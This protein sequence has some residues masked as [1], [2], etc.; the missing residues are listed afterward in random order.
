MADYY[1][2]LKKTIGS[3]PE[4][5]GAARRSVYSRARNAIVNQLKAYEPPL[6]PSEITAEQLRLEEAIRKVEAE[7]ARESLGLTAK[8]KAPQTA[9]PALSTESPKTPPPSPAVEV[10]P[11]VP[12][13]SEINADTSS[14]LKRVVEEAENLGEATHKAV[15]STKEAMTN[16]EPS[17]GTSSTSSRQE[18]VLGGYDS[19]KEPEESRSAPDSQDAADTDIFAPT[20]PEGN[21]SPQPER[22]S[23][24]R[25]R[26]S[27]ALNAR[28]GKFPVLPV[29]LIGVLV[30]IAVGIAVVVFSQKDMLSDMMAGGDT[31]SDQT[32]DVEA[33]TGTSAP[34]TGDDNADVADNQDDPNKNEDRLL[35]DNGAPAAAPDARSVTTTLI[36]PNATSSSGNAVPASPQ[37]DETA[38]PAGTLDTPVEDLPA[39]TAVPGEDTAPVIAGDGTRFQK[40]ILYEEGETANGAGSAS[41][42]QVV[43]S[44]EEET[45]L[46][47]AKQS[48]LSAVVNVPERN[49]SVDIR[50]KPN[51]DPS[52]PASHL[53]E[54]KYDFPEDFPAG[55][56]VN[57]PG[58]VMKPTEEARGDALIGASVKVSPGYF[59]I[60]LSSIPSEMER[61]MGLLRE[62]GWVDIPMLYDNGKRGI[63]TLEKGETGTTAVEDAVSAWQGG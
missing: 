52:L 20:A 29:A 34:V 24:D 16:E 62:R 50:I 22:K 63:L 36:T 54:I 37:T 53:V 51:D 55:D 18:P 17:K 44:V 26:A 41:Q 38:T 4:S 58:L 47:G 23:R 48:V 33:G 45:D 59:W 46:E 9:S 30:L 8:P 12:G 5:N 56:V 39:V 28:G 35:D 11:A 15:L 60:A 3:L 40:S 14:P 32:G 25:Q 21:E 13:A 42:G 19:R 6:S 57:V 49:V 61:N 43:W 7:A 31:P 2:I 1:S 10:K 27:D